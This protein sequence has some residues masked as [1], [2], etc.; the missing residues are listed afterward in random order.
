MI[1]RAVIY[2]HNRSSLRINILGRL[3]PDGFCLL[4]GL[5]MS[6][7]AGAVENASVISESVAHEGNRLWIGNI[8]PRITE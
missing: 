2:E 4:P 5:H 1:L 7:A 3:N 8:D 6:S